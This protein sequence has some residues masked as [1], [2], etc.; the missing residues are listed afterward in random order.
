MTIKD[1]QP[2]AVWENFYGLTRIPRPSKHE[3]KVQEY[4][5]EWGK[6][7]G[8]DVKRDDTGHKGV[9]GSQRHN[10]AG[11]HGHGAAENSGH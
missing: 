11:S 8:V 3:A 6:K 7:N 4:L 5:L 9:R 1:L 2:K 10:N